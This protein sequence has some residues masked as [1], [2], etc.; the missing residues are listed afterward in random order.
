MPPIDSQPEPSKK[1]FGVAE[2]TRRIR[3]LIEDEVGSVWVEGEISNLS[4]PASGHIYFTI[5]D[6]DAQLKGAYFKGAQRGK[7]F[8][9]LQNGQKIRLFGRI[10]VYEPRG[11]YQIIVQQLEEAGIGNLQEAFEKLKRQL[12][13]EGLFKEEHKKALPAMPRHIGLITSDSGA[14]IQDML[15]V[16]IRRFPALRVTLYPISVQGAQAAPEIAEALAWFNRTTDRPDLLIVGRGGGSIEDLWAFNEELT[17]RAIYQST[18]PIISAVGHEPDFTIADFVADQRAPTPSAAAEIAVPEY[19]SLW[20][21]LSICTQR[22]TTT[23]DNYRL[24]LKTRYMQAARSY[25]FKEPE[26]LVKQYKDQLVHLQRTQKQ[27]L[28]NAAQQAEQRIDVIQQRMTHLLERQMQQSQQRVDELA[29]QHEHVMQRK[30]DG[31]QKRLE[32]L[33]S[34]LQ[35]MNPQAVLNRGYSI[36]MNSA[37]EVIHQAQEV[38]IGTPLLTQLNSGRI[39][40]TVTD[41][42]KN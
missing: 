10:S 33:Q 2:I 30:I 42:E 12:E 29:V 13:A 11:E 34:K 17:A 25:V 23:L 26:H 7:K 3:Y 32:I 22:L 6:K 36:T 14:V 31:S 19:E 20:H 21:H 9:E 18:I 24:R 27:A 16:L 5:K 35:A 8:Q 37:G 28:Y 1:V 15:H 4:R 38:A 41:S 40:S 39:H